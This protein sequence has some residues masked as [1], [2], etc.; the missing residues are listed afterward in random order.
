[1]L[2]DKDS[3]VRAAAAWTLAAQEEPG[4]IAR[5]AEA[6]LQKEPDAK[7][8]TRLYQ[9]LG[10]QENVDIGGRIPGDIEQVKPDARAAGYDL[11]A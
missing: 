7:V 3:E 6:I 9:A 10:N 8:R 4:N 5:E 11:F 2:H 1:M